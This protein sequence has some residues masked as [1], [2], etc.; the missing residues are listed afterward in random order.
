MEMI[1]PQTEALFNKY[2]SFL[3][4]GFLLERYTTNI[5]KATPAQI[6]RATKDSISE[7][8]LPFWSF[9]FMLAFW[10]LMLIGVIT[11]FVLAC[12]NTIQN[13]RW[14]QWCLVLGTP[15]PWL[16]SEFGWLTA[17]FGR[18]P[19]T[20]HGI[21]PTYMSV[22]SL[23]TATVAFSLGG[24]V[25]LYASLF[26]VEICLMLKF[27]NLGPSSLGEKRYHFEKSNLPLTNV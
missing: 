10:V 26:V 17:E 2:Q 25:L 15:L 7:V 27:I 18:Q 21:L 9:R 8:W 23:S 13:H 22:S 5:D 20:V 16:A 3:G 14:L 11:A 19:W 4:W 6:A 12:R 1:P 24:F